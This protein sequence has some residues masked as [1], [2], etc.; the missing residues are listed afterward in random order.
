MSLGPSEGSPIFWFLGLVVILFSVLSFSLG[1]TTVNEAV[2]RGSSIAA[3]MFAWLIGLHQYIFSMF[4]TPSSRI[5]TH[6]KSA[7]IRSISSLFY[8]TLFIA[9]FF[10]DDTTKINKSLYMAILSLMSLLWA[11]VLYR[12]IRLIEDTP[13]GRLNSIAQGYAVLRGKVSLYDGETARGPHKELPI[14]VWYSKYLYTSSAGFLLDDGNGTC[15]IDPRDAEVITPRH[16]YGSYAF[17]AIYPD[18]T[19]YVIGHFETLS[20]QR[21]EH[22][23]KALVSSKIIEWKRN[24]VKFLDYFDRNNDG[25]VDDVEMAGV[26]NAADRF[27]DD[28][29]EEVYQQPASHVVSQPNDGRPFILSSIHPDELIKRYKHA[30][31]FH[32]SAWI[33]LTV[34]LFA[35]RAI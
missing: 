28:S 35:M 33:I 30:M 15:T 17:Y 12:R 25:V 16:H 1:D 13:R 29:L 31:F 10:L 20:K 7:L 14:M 19:V 22:E 3:L 23:R 34:F 24:R 2:F 27:V 6:V 8:L 9:V 5:I 4:F 26:R 32:L 11:F 21:N 18:E